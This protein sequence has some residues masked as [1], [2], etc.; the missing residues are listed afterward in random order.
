VWAGAVRTGD[1]ATEQRAAD[2]ILGARTWPSIT[3]TDPD[4]ADESEFAWLP[5]L[6]QA[7]RS[8]D[9]AAARAALRGNQSCMPGL[10][11]ELRLGK[12]W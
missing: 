4:M 3:D 5:D 6:E 12:R 11:P 7:I 1:T 8:D 9:R 2:V 10:A